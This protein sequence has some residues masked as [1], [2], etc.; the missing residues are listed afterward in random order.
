M[1]VSG[2]ALGPWLLLAALAVILYF[3]FRIVQPFLLPVFL[4]LILS[5]LLSPLHERFVLKLN[6]RGGLPAVFVSGALTLT[7]LLPI[8]FLS[9]SLANEANDVY[10]QLKNPDKLGRIERWLDPNDN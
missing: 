3:C 1:T 2:R 8:L 4:A 7:I 10:Q 9:F 5:T 6:G